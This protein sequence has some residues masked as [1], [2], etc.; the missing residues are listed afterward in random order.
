MLSLSLD[1]TSRLSSPSLT[2]AIASGG[3]YAGSLYRASRPGGQWHADGVPIAGASGPEWTMTMA[4]EGAAITYRLGPQTSNTIKMWMPTDLPAS[5]RINGGW[6]D[7]KRSITTSSGRV[8]AIADQFGV[9]PM[10]QA[11]VANQPDYTPA[12][13][14]GGPAIVW[15]ETANTRFLAPSAPFAPAYW[16]FVMRYRN[17]TVATF[18]SDAAVPDGDYPAIISSGA[19]PNRVMGERSTANLFQTSVWTGTAR[20]NAAPTPSATLLP[21]PKSLVELQGVPVSALWSLGRG[22][23]AVLDDPLAAR[24]WRGTMYE[25]VALGATPTQHDLY[26]LQGY[27]AWRNAV[28]SQLSVSHFY[29]NQAPRREP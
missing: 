10:V 28:Q 1:I 12:A 22:A 7:P 2:I 25:V 17:G 3:G 20:K 15:P 23:G 29:K 8:S 13:S 4:L 6:W 11:T 9:R 24:S 18:P 14:D 19:S 21:L 26:L 27:M 16:I 5:Y